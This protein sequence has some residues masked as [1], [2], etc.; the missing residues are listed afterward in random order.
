[1]TQGLMIGNCQKFFRAIAYI[2]TA[3]L[4]KFLLINSPVPVPKTVLYI[5]L[6]TAGV[7]DSFLVFITYLGFRDYSLCCVSARSGQDQNLSQDMCADAQ[8]D[9]G[10]L[11]IIL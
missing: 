8:T 3:F 1:M 2:D 5:W 11:S 9:F 7:F 4:Y 6:R 10:S